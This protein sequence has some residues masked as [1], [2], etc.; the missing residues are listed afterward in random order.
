MHHV[1]VTVRP[2]REERPKMPA[3]DATGLAWLRI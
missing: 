1:I 2:P 3:L